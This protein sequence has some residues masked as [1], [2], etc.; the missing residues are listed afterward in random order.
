MRVAIVG[1]GV[2]GLLH[3]I[4]FARSPLIKEVCLFAKDDPLETTSVVAGAI[5]MPYKVEPKGKAVKWAAR[6]I[7]L[8][9]EYA[10]T[11]DTGVAFRTHTEFFNKKANKPE[12]MNAASDGEPI[13]CQIPEETETTFSVKIP[14]IDTVKF[15]SFLFNAATR[16]GVHITK[17]K[18]LDFNELEGFDIIINA[19]GVG[20]GELTNDPAV[21]PIKGQTFTIAQPEQ[22]I[23]QSVFYDD[24]ELVTLIAPHENHI[25]IGVTARDNDTSTNYDMAMEERLLASISRFYPQLADAEVLERRVGHRPGRTGGIRLE[26]EYNE[27]LGKWVFH[28]YGHAGGGIAL[29]PACVEELSDEVFKSISARL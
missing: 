18:I 6:S 27:R 23:N 16:L 17:Q 1:G 24:G 14:V 3:A 15:M 4:T 12:W 26:K 5:W 19:A 7:A 13:E 2:I 8:F 28:N 20:A 9:R 25:R 11:P 21:F 10:D 22:K 29:A